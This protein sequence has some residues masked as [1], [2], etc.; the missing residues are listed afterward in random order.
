MIEPGSRAPEFIL[1]SGEGKEVSL[2]E[3][4]GS[5]MVLYFYP[6]DNTSG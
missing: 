4:L 6:K 2:K 1:N 5:W 3:E